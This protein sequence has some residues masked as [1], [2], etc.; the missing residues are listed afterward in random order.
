MRLNL[1]CG[2]QVVKGWTNVDYALGAKIS[3]FPLFRAFNNKVKLFNVSWND[4]IY[5][6]NLT[7]KFPW[8]DNTVDV[9]YSSHTLEHFSKEEGLAFLKECHRVLRKG[10][11]IRIVVPD[12]KSVI[13]QYKSGQIRA[14]EFVQTLG[15]L[16][17]KKNNFIKN[18]LAPFIQ[19]P[20]KCMY[21]TT[22]LVDILNNIG[23]E[24]NSRTSLDS[25]ISDIEGIELEDRTI[26]A[27]IVEGKKQ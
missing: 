18:K 10:G 11:T 6:H 27:V 19:F 9:V 21:D 3:K 23:F 22:S 8:Q 7:Q 16:Y 17:T 24:A 25:D 13:E 4:E 15:V 2:P 12:L 20:H 26:N 5:L 14:D 1:G